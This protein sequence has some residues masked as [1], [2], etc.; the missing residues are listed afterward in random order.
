MHEK[1]EQ[2]D[3]F[4]NARVIFDQKLESKIIIW[5]SALIIG[6]ILLLLISLFYRFKSYDIYYAKVVKNEEDSYIQFTVNEDFLKKKN[7]NYLIINDEEVHCQLIKM[8]DN[9]YLIN[10]SKYWEAFFD[11]KLEKELNFDSNVLEVKIDNGDIT[12]Y[13]YFT[14]KLRKVVRSGRVKS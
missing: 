7:R 11:C 13:Q 5:I 6:S 10:A 3:I 2:I 1:L 9:Y 14:N 8:S 12:L 4:N